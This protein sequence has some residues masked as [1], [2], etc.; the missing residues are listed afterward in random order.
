MIGSPALAVPALP[1]PLSPLVGRERDTAAICRL[2]G[3]D[4]IRLLTLTG[5]GGVGKTRLALEVARQLTGTFADGAVFVELAPITDPDLVWPTI[6]RA[7][8]LADLGEADVVEGLARALTGAQLLLVLDNIEQVLPA[9]GGVPRLLARCPAVNALL[10]S[11]V[12][13]RVG[14]AHEYPVAPLAV[15]DL[16]LTPPDHLAHNAAVSLF[17]QRARAVRPDFALTTENAPVVAGICARLDGLPLAIELAAAR[18]RL[19]SPAALLTRLSHRLRLLTDGPDDAP[20]RLRTMHGAIAWS[21]DGLGPF[22][23]AV[24]RRLA[25]FAGGFAVEAAEAVCGDPGG[26]AGDHIPTA[27]AAAGVPVPRSAGLDVLD[28]LTSLVDKS[29]LRRTTGSNS[30]PRL[31]LLETV[32][33]FALE[34]LEAAGEATAIGRRQAEFLLSVVERAAPEFAGPTGPPWLARF[35]EERD[36]LRSALGWALAHGEADLALRLAGGLDQFWTGRG[37][38]SEGRSWLER[39]LAA[40]PAAPPPTRGWGLTALSRIAWRQGDL[41]AAATA[42]ET[43]LATFRALGE[44]RGIAAALRD[45]GNAVSD[46]GDLDRGA[47]LYEEALPLLLDL[48]DTRGAAILLNNLGST[49]DGR[50][51]LPQARA[52]FEQALALLRQLADPPATAVV[53]QNLGDV[54]REQGDYETAAARYRESLVLWREAGDRWGLAC[55]LPSI[56]TLA[57]LMGDPQRAAGLFGAAEG[58]LDAVG[59]RHQHGVWDRAQPALAAVRAQLGEE[60]FRAHAAR[61]RALTIDQ[62]LDKPPLRRGP[63]AKDARHRPRRGTPLRQA[64]AQGQLRLRYQP[65][66][67]LRTDRVVGVEA[68]VRWQHPA[69]GLLSPIDFIPLAEETG[70]VVPLDH[71]VWQ[72]TCRQAACWH[73]ATGAPPS[74]SARTSRRATCARRTSRSGLRTS[75]RLRVWSRRCSRWRL[76]S[77]PPLKTC[78]SPVTRCRRFAPSVC[79]SRSMTLAPDSRR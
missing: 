79:G 32:R 75:W 7:L 8:G 41:A 48:G 51:D 60:D 31:S 74:P 68:L 71:W 62:I 30:E 25:V 70:L 53:L 66:V 54:T 36:N 55:A 16:A 39:A 78:R 13:V 17:V 52:L 67:D 46:L 27:S 63:E 57:D 64:I 6:A 19:L 43:A 35:E 40:T 45:L 5:P 37:H 56:A 9:A 2:L 61:G 15:P 1:S 49:A 65:Q 24:F 14:G 3:D 11:R 76:P 18:T 44:T 22:E 26:G 33:E 69:R 42:A 47:V 73:T 34:R 20:A 59:G 4:N 21:Y 72:E 29:L 38:L 10:T 77:R 58:L 12:A 50:R 28:A 23:Q